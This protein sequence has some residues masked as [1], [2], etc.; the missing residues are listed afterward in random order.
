MHLY[1]CTACLAGGVMGL[2]LC[3]SSVFAR[4][5]LNKEFVKEPYACKPVTTLMFVNWHGL[6]SCS[7]TEDN[8]D[9]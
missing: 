1:T 4:T 5:S 2:C 8:F 6:Q 7:T 3:C 9:G